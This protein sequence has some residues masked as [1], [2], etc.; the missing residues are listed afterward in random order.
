MARDVSQKA[1]LQ[2]WTHRESFRGEA[3]FKSWLLRITTN[4]CNNELRRAWR[5]RELS[6]E[7]D[8]APR[9]LGRTEARAFEALADSEARK[10]L[11]GAVD[12]L[13]EQQQKVALLRLYSDLSFKEV[14]EICGITPNNAKVNFHHAVRNIRKFLAARGVAA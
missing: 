7:G 3:S 11:R 10:H 2:A 13:P 1:F 5:R 14:G 4:V 8:D 6:A 12:Q 9:E